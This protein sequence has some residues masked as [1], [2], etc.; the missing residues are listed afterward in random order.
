MTEEVEYNDDTPEEERWSAALVYCE[1]VQND[2]LG[3]IL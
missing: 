1:E 3:G 2:F